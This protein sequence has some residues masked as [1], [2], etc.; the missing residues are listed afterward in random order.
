MLKF[1]LGAAKAAAPSLLSLAYVG[2]D[3][4]LGAPLDTGT[5]QPI[6]YGL[7]TS[8]AVYLVPNVTTGGAQ[9][10]AENVKV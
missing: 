3:L 6:L 9:E 10:S 8:L 1:L 7:V 5:L 2:V 4:L